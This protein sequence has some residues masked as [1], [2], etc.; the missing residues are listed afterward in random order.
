L[1]KRFWILSIKIDLII[2]LIAQ[3]KRLDPFR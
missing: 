2:V 3:D 1:V